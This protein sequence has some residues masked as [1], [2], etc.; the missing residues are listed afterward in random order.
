MNR[1][2]PPSGFCIYVHTLVDGPVPVERNECGNPVVYAT[3]DEAEREIALSVQTRIEEY[4]HGARE[5]EDA[6]TVE[7]FIVD[8][9]VM[10]DGSIVD[11]DGGHFGHDNW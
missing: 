1:S 3:R 11:S 5:F 8:V 10:S 9:D 6:L 2:P 4:L 7:E